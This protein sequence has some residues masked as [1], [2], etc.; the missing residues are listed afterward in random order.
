MKDCPGSAAV[1]DIQ[2]S[3]LPRHSFREL[4][5]QIPVFFYD[6]SGKTKIEFKKTV[7]QMFL[8]SNTGK[9]Q[10][11]FMWWELNM[12]TEGK[13]QKYSNCYVYFVTFVLWLSR[14]NNRVT[15][16]WM[17]LK[18]TKALLIFFSDQDYNREEMAL[19]TVM[20]EPSLNLGKPMLEDYFFLL[21]N[22]NFY[23]FWT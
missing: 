11:V 17:Y 3:Q 9:A 6:W 23:A 21:D 5:D 13:I 14:F 1:H 10:M 7:K 16:P 12:D 19:P 2:L 15:L 18:G 8:V 4:S 20:W 22:Y